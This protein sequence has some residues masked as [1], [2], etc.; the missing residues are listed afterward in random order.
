MQI[1]KWF[2]VLVLGGVAMA[3]V[4]CTEQH[5][6]S[7]GGPQNPADGGDESDGPMVHGGMDASAAADATSASD[8]GLSTD[9]GTMEASDA[10]PSADAGTIVDAAAP[11]AT[12]MLMCSTPA[13]PGDPCGC[14]CCWAMSYL[15]TD[16]EC[17]AFCMAGN[18]GMGCCE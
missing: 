11:D 14:P 2:K 16:P 17:A 15:N 4:A 7:T 9:V 6:I 10:S 13:A 12:V 18:N 8:S 5:R 3:M 1:E